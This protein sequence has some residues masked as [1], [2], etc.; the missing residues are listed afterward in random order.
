MQHSVRKSGSFGSTPDGKPIDIWTLDNG[1][2]TSA[3]VLSLGGIVTHLRVPD[4]TGK[5]GDVLLGLSGVAPIY[6][7][8]WCYLNSLVGRVANRITNGKFTLDGKSYQTSLNYHGVHTLHGGNAGYDR[9]IWN[10]EPLAGADAAIRLTLTDPDGA[11]GFPGTVKVSVVYTIT[12]QGTWR[13]EYE[14]TTDQPTPIN[15]TQHAY[16]NLK[17]AGKSPV[18]D[19]VLKLNASKYT[20]NNEWLLPTGEI[21]KAA[22]TPFDFRAPKPIGQDLRKLTNTP[23]G[24]DVNYPIDGADGSLREC[25]EVYEPTTGRVMTCLTT[26]PAVQL[27]TGNF[28]EGAFTGDDGTAYQQHT[29][30]CLET[31]RYPNA[32]NLP[33]FPNTVLRPNETYRQATEY[34]FSTR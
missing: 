3:D 20:P 27:Y 34:R 9:K 8:D 19:H 21:V 23:I 4:R 12:A 14:A 13:I 6:K 22:G 32:I 18:Y 31:Q 24:Y 10:V 16:F 15:L 26:E 33:Q 28:L 25:A 17:D 1:R 5:S 2:G 29:A 11:E 7:A 30:F